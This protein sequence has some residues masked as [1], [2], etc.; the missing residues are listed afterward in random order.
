M[1]DEIDKKIFQFSEFQFRHTG[2]GN[3]VAEVKDGRGQAFE[4]L[5][6]N[7]FE[8]RLQSM[9]VLVRDPSNNKHYVFAKGA[10]E[11]IFNASRI[12]PAEFNSKIEELSLGG[13]RTL[14]VAYKEVAPH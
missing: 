8:S 6:I 5:K 13:Y 10:P 11:K 14:A 12:K 3:V 4:I 2:R 7:Q 9:S 1:G